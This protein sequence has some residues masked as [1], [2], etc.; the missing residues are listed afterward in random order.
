MSAHAM[1]GAAYWT[2]VLI[3]SLGSVGLVAWFLWA[4]WPRKRRPMARYMPR[5][6]DDPRDGQRLF[7]E[8][9]KP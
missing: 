7:R 2:F 9:M 4:V 6:W 3:V 1:L 8:S 5:P